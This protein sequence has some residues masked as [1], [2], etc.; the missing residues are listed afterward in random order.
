M[1]SRGSKSDW[2][3]QSGPRWRPMW[4]S[5]RDNSHF[6]TWSLSEQSLRLHQAGSSYTRNTID[7]APPTSLHYTRSSCRLQSNTLLDV[8]CW[9]HDWRRWTD[10]VRARTCVAAAA[11]CRC[12]AV[13]TA[14]AT[15]GGRCISPGGCVHLCHR[16]SA[17]HNYDR[18]GRCLVRTS[19]APPTSLMIKHSKQKKLR[20]K[21][22]QHCDITRQQQGSHSSSISRE[23]TATQGTAKS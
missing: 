21:L 19:G 6:F 9:L 7:W 4:T 16:K 18:L 10:S 14:A 15:T 8:N 2:S 3:V 17:T 5:S 12:S 23:G 13:A 20:H 1:A 11:I 22:R